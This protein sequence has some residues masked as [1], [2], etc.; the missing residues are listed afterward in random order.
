MAMSDNKV[1]I[2]GI[3]LMSSAGWYTNRP[4]ARAG[5]GRQRQQAVVIRQFTY[6]SFLKWMHCTCRFGD[7]SK[8]PTVRLVCK[9]RLKLTCMLNQNDIV[10]WFQLK[11]SR[12]QSR[13]DVSTNT[14]IS[15]TW[16]D[17][18][19]Y[20]WIVDKFTLTPHS[21]LL[22][23][24]YNVLFHDVKLTLSRHWFELITWAG[25]R[26]TCTSNHLSNQLKSGQL[27]LFL[28]WPSHS[29]PLIH[30]ASLPSFH[31]ISFNSVHTSHLPF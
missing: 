29:L 9:V 27:V 28:N 5:S 31:F 19:E 4:W 13:F 17:L 8:G 22:C 30:P 20:S 15:T 21:M 2:E 10:C 25:P 18:R 1:L 7:K 3:N 11:N 16:Q 14:I 12:E 26:L 6:L 23:D 24:I